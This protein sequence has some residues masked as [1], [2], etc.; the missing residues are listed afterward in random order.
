MIQP[1]L[2]TA[3]SHPSRATPTLHSR[4]SQNNSAAALFRRGLDFIGNNQAASAGF[5][6][7]IVV[8][9]LLGAGIACIACWGLEWK[10]VCAR[11]RR[12]TGEDGKEVLPAR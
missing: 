1:L 9:A 6:V 8:A 4:A 10:A 5:V 11:S 12:R 7:V 3:L 2:P